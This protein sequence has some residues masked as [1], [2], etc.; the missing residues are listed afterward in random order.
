MLPLSSPKRVVSYSYRVQ[1]RHTF[2]LDNGFRANTLTRPRASPLLCHEA[3]M[4]DS[5]R[6]PSRE[7]R[8]STCEVRVCWSISIGNSEVEARWVCSRHRTRLGN[9]SAAV[10]LSN[11]FARRE[12]R[13]K[14][15][16]DPRMKGKGPAQRVDEQPQIAGVANGAIGTA[17]NQCMP[18]LDG[19]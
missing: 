10:S 19:H 8:A 14:Q 13:R 18:G 15:H 17:R 11:V 4:Y 6:R 2:D 9:A 7:G 3:S 12:E 16:S 1:Q 5:P